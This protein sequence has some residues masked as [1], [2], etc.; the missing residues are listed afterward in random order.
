M[1]AKKSGSAPTGTAPDEITINKDQARLLTELLDRLKP[2]DNLTQRDWNDIALKV[3]T[4]SAKA[5]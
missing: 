1:P 3:G 2:N 4:K 5:A